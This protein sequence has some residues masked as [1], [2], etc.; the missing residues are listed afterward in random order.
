MLL[1]FR[2]PVYGQNK[3][4]IIKEVTMQLL[5][6]IANFMDFQKMNSGKKYGQELRTFSKQV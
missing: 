5:Q 2:Q 4:L 3:I 1:Y 6:A